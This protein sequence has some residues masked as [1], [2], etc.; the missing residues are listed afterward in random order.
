MNSLEKK[1]LTKIGAGLIATATLEAITIV[2]A[3]KITFLEG[4]N[5]NKES[6]FKRYAISLTEGFIVG[7]GC[8]IPL[9]IAGMDFYK[10]NR[11]R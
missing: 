7:A 11:R 8:S 10:T 3:E 6:K 4:K 1:Y 5:F 2:N 9:L